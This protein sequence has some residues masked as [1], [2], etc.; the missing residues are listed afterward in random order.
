VF[1]ILV[2]A[3]LFAQNPSIL[4][5]AAGCAGADPAIVSVAVKGMTPHGD[6]N[7]YHLGGT[8][9]NVGSRKQA[10]NDL[11]FVDVYQDRQKVDSRGIPPLRPGQSYTFGYDYRRAA[12]A[13]NRSTGFRFVIDWR[14]P[15]P[16]GS[17]DCNLGNDSFTLRV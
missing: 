5:A 10:S 9:T 2:S 12:D 16:P 14:Q 15:S 11:Y 4:V 6:V 8:V 7:V 17:Q 13:A 3:V 1:A